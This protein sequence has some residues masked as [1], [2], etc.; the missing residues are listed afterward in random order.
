MFLAALLTT[1]KTHNTVNQLYFDKFFKIAIS[2]KQLRQPSVV[3][4]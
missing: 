2:W 3:N 1:A 4:Q